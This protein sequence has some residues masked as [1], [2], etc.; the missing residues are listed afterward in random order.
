M[1]SL[2]GQESSPPDRVQST[3]GVQEFR[4]QQSDQGTK[5]RLGDD[6]ARGP[7]SKEVESA[8]RRGQLGVDFTE[9]GQVKIRGGS[10]VNKMS[11][12]L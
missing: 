1:P 11:Y 10:P 7:R 3:H 2:P 8:S 9:E 6:Q 5:G 4:A 12:N